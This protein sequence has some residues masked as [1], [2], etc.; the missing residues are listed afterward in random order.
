MTSW[1]SFSKAQI[2]GEFFKRNTAIS[3]VLLLCIDN[4]FRQPGEA[5]VCEVRSE[6]YL[7]PRAEIPLPEQ[8]QDSL[9]RIPEQWSPPI[10]NGEN[11]RLE[12]EGLGYKKARP[13]WG[14][15]FWGGHEMSA[16]R[17]RMSARSL[18]EIL[19]GQRAKAEFDEAH[20]FVGSGTSQAHHNPF[21]HALK[22][23]FTITAVKLERMLD[24]DD[25]WIEFQLAGPDP[26]IAPFRT[27]NPQSGN[28]APG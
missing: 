18:V 20:G 12:I 19:A 3:F 26:A 27:Q 16:H 5:R 24:Q 13:F 17:F 1:D 9:R 15:S 14:H 22:R 10:Q 25:D 23:G 6:L 8:L 2:I 21:E 4:P 11:A 28:S 7:D